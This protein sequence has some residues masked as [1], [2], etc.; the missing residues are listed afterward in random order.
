MKKSG[1]REL[2]FMIFAMLLLVSTALYITGWPWVPYSFAASGA[3]VAVWLLSDTYHGQNSR[4][5]R[6]NFQQ[7][8]AALLLPASSWLM[9]R[10][11][12]EWFI[13]LLIS[14]LLILY[15]TIIRH[16]EEPK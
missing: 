6:L 7:T 13:A 12:N 8:L 1:I 16:R 9:F 10:H 4:L 2:L 15:I 5:R 14:A 11:R 3:G